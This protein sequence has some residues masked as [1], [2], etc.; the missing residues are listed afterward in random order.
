MT[1][2]QHTTPES[3]A[4]N[5]SLEP[6]PY[7]VNMN[8]K[9]QGNQAISSGYPAAGFNIS[10]SAPVY[11]V[12]VQGPSQMP[13]AGNQAIS[14]G[15]PAAGFNIPVS[16]PVYPVN[17]QD[18]SQMPATGWNS[19]VYP[20]P[21]PPYSESAFQT[22][23]VLMPNIILKTELRDIPAQ[24]VCPSCNLPCVTKTE[25]TSGC[26]TTL[27][28]CLLFFFGCLLGC[29]LIPCCVNSCKDVN[30]YCPNCKHLIHKY[31]RL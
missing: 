31:K 10:V 4:T 24:T 11:P 30:H 22:Q 27:L 23:T 19:S 17:V 14:S 16:A 28:C 12:N 15:Y 20:P 26:L 29:C 7:M 8:G 25:Y 6:P 18:P 1:S 3:P 2:Q 9:F 21:L 5:I 13:A